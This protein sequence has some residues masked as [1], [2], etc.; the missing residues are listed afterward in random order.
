[1]ICKICNKNIENYRGLSSHINKIHK[2]SCETYYSKFYKKENEDIC[3]TCGKHTPFISIKDGYKKHCNQ[4]CAN[5]DINV[6]NT[7]KETCIS[8]YGV[9]SYM[10]TSV[11]RK[12][13]IQAILT[14]ETKEKRKQTMLKKYGNEYAISTDQVK[15]KCKSTTL[16]RYGVE[17][18][19]QSKEIQ[20]KAKETLV[21][22]YNV[23]IHKHI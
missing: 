6:L 13:A 7:K 3:P 2:I 14:Q 12:K 20:E 23:L 18:A 4:K 17:Y 10:K 5:N 15:Q 1:M 21:K 22:T 16:K 8:K 19:F 11:F 9:S